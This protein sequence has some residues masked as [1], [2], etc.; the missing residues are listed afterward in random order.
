LIET[1][2]ATPLKDALWKKK[3][4]RSRKQT[5]IDVGDKVAT[6]RAYFFACVPYRD[7]FDVALE[8]LDSIDV[9]FICAFFVR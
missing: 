9:F 8:N 4:M 5:T 3:F 2:P 1:T 7:K 6:T